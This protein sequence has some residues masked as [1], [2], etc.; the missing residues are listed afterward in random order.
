M[1]LVHK[2]DKADRVLY[3]FKQAFITHLLNVRQ[4]KSK[5]YR[6]IDLVMEIIKSK[7]V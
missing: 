6:L 4:N 5:T 7:Q 1:F 2:V 3:K